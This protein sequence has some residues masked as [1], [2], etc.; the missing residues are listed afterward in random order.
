MIE[1]EIQTGIGPIYG[2]VWLYFYRYKPF[3]Y[4]FA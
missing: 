4:L 3:R 2:I 1:E